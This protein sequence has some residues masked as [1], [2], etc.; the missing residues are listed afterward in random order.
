MKQVALWLA[1]HLPHLPLEALAETPAPQARAATHSRGSRRWIVAAN[2]AALAPGL[3]LGL[4]RARRPDLLA[5]ERRPERELQALET[6]A[7]AA[8][9]FG[10][11]IAWSVEEP[12]RDFGVPRFTL[13]LEIGASLRLFGGIDALLAKI[14]GEFAALDHRV[15]FAVAPTLEAAAALARAGARDVL[16]PEGLSDALAPLPLPA[17]SLPADALELLHD[18]GL[19]TVGELLA[20]PRPALGKRIGADVLAY[21]DRLSGAR[22]D[23]RRWYRPP[24]RFARRFDFDSEVEDAERLAFPLRRLLGEFVR[25]LRARATGVQQFRFELVHG[26][27]LPPT[28]L[29]LT[30]SAPS[31]DE[32]LLLRVLR[33][34]LAVA[35]MPAP[36]RGVSLIAE[37]FAA[38][39]TAQHDLFDDR[40]HAEE[41]AAAVVDRLAARLGAGAVWRL[42]VVADH[43]PERAWRAIAPGDRMLPPAAFPLRPAWLL[44]EPRR[45][46]R[47]PP[48]A[49]ANN[50]ERIESGWWDGGDARRDYFACELER[51]VRGWAYFDHRDGQN[52][53]HGLWA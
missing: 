9:G 25:Y 51:G 48:L 10:D 44:R 16:D 36:A 38:P 14:D 28:L 35:T 5:A 2:D 32:A 29:E 13:W 49:A 20:L 41:E 18:T 8:Y 42:G 26:G 33:E 45:L 7:C 53:L 19:R 46:H 3:D 17:L 34:K 6:L 12:E 40:P 52:Y 31:R 21:L 27:E 39:R 1:A 37:R 11:R 4:A 24:P 50:V 22:P 47:P 23:T 43:R 30:L 15:A